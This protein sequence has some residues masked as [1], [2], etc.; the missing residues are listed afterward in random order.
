[1]FAARRVG[2][3][4]VAVLLASRGHPARLELDVLP[5]LP[6]DGLSDEEARTLLV[7][8]RRGPVDERV[9]DRIVA[10]ARGNPLILCEL[11]AAGAAGPYPGGFAV[12]IRN[13]TAEPIYRSRIESLPANTR[14]LLLVAAAEPTGSPTLLWAA[15]GHLG[16]LPIDAV[17]AQESGLL[18]VDQR[19]HLAHP[20]VRTAIYR[21]SPG[22]ERRVAH[23]ALAA[24]TDA[25]A[26]SRPAGVASRAGHDGPRRERRHRPRPI[27]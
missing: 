1:M 14:R 13:R 7:S 8:T 24:V 26:R 21:T 5:S 22:A 25:F 2:S 4:A 9:V 27:S 18:V 10:E 15:A 6:V 3:D 20:L 19:V 11:A 16:L 17:P 12:G 23:A